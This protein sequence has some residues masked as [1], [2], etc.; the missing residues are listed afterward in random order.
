MRGFGSQRVRF[1]LAR[2]GISRELA[3]VVLD[4]QSDEY[5][6]AYKLALDKLAHCHDEDKQ[7]LYRKLAGFLQRRG[8]PYEIVS[9]VVKEVLVRGDEEA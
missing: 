9:R 2:K 1:E 8:Y 6:R 3:D 5:Q 4:E 7:V